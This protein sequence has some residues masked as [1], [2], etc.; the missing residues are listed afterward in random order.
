MDSV[1]AEIECL[2]SMYPN[3]EINPP[4]FCES[5]M[6]PVSGSVGVEIQDGP[7]IE[8]NFTLRAG[9]EE[10]DVSPEKSACS[11]RLC[12]E[13]LSRSDVDRL[14]SWASERVAA[15]EGGG[16][17][18]VGIA[19]SLSDAMEALEV[20]PSGTLPTTE[21]TTRMAAVVEP[22]VKVE[23]KMTTGEKEAQKHHSGMLELQSG[24]PSRCLSALK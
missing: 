19:M 13:K 21:T 14:N 3:T 11:V 17:E 24:S 18:I 12:S 4:N 15:G 6:F 20:N 1:V 2:A 8:L 23:F 5:A 9:Y 10:G 16:M 7:V 22:A